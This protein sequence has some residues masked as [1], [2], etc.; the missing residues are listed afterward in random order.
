MSPREKRRAIAAAFGLAVLLSLPYLAALGV[1]PPERAY[2]GHIWNP[3][4]PNVY[5]A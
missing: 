4:E 1:T 5:Y 3:D 2:M